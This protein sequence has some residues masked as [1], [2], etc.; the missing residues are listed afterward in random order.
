MG[1]RSVGNEVVQA[2]YQAVALGLQVDQAHARLQHLGARDEHG[3]QVT[4]GGA[5]IGQR[6]IRALPGQAQA[7]AVQALQLA[8]QG[9]QFGGVVVEL[10]QVPTRDVVLLGLQAFQFTQFG[11]DHRHLAALLLPGQIERDLE[12]NHVAPLAP[13]PVVGN[14]P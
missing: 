13:A 7:R 3:A 14:L 5:V 11:L 9:L 1:L 12:R 2:H 6:Q 10:L 8:L 4:L